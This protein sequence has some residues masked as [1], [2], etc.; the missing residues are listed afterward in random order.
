[1]K[2]RSGIKN[3]FYSLPGFSFL[4]SKSSFDGVSLASDKNDCKTESKNDSKTERKKSS[5]S[6]QVSG[7]ETRVISRATGCVAHGK[8]PHRQLPAGQDYTGIGCRESRREDGP[9]ILPLVFH[10]Y[11]NLQL[12]FQHVLSGTE[13]Q[14]VPLTL[15]GAPSRDWHIIGQDG[16]RC[17]ILALRWRNVGTE[18]TQLHTEEDLQ[19]GQDLLLP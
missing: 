15:T 7:H 19:Q 13:S 2:W 17:E 6:S 1:M 4:R 11:H 5:S 3:S 12:T 9:Q 8:S 10:H 16:E 18:A 14:T